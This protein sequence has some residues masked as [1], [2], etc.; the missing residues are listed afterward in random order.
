MDPAREQPAQS[1]VWDLTLTPNGNKLLA[2]TH[3]RGQWQI[4]EP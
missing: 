2:G 3:G 4:P 1:R